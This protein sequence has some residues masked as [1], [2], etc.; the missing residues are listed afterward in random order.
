MLYPKYK[1]LQEIESEQ[2]EKKIKRS[3]QKG[4][5]KRKKKGKKT[6]R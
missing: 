5:Q 6:H 4:K 1:S 3:F 2:R